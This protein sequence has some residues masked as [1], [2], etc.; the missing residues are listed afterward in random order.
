MKTLTIKQPFASLIIEGQKKY[1][2][3]TW[4]TN[5]RGEILI[6]A[7]KCTD[8]KELERLKS[9]N[10]NTENGAIIGKVTI[11]DCIL[12]DKDFQ[13]K[14]K[15]ENELVYEKMINKDLTE[16]KIYAFKLE[17]V[18]KI[19]PIKVNGKLSFWEYDFKDK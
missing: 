12:V 9:L 14:L 5:Y 6:H 4:K 13:K 15:K 7:G 17:N 2:F 8:K 3:R 16:E 11:T 10:L 1:E 18:K 19:V